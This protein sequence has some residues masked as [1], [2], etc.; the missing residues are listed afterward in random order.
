MGRATGKCETIV[1][2]K[3][4]KILIFIGSKN[5]EHSIKIIHSFFHFGLI[6]WVVFLKK[7]IKCTFIT[8]LVKELL[9][10]LTLLKWTNLKYISTFSKL[11]GNFYAFAIYSPLM[12]DNSWKPFPRAVRCFGEEPVVLVLKLISTSKECT[13]SLLAMIVLEVMTSWLRVFEQYQSIASNKEKRL[14]LER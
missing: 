10:I 7:Y 9:F 12:A 13:H 14:N 11:L 5:I 1:N 3:K 2:I 4:A 6:K 8:T